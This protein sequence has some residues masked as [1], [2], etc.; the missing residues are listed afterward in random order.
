MLASL[1]AHT[2]R[3]VSTADAANEKL[4]ARDLF[5]RVVKEIQITD[6][7]D[8]QRTVRGLGDDVDLWVELARLWEGDSLEKTSRALK[9]ALRISRDKSGEDGEDPRLLNNL[10][11]LRHLEGN[12]EEARILYEGAITNAAKS[13]EELSTTILYNLARCYE[14]LREVTLAQEAYDKLLAR[15]PEY[16]DGNTI[17]ILYSLTLTLP[18]S[19]NSA[20]AN[21]ARPQP[22]QRCS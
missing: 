8:K 10:A 17:L 3:G 14:D 11:A 19:Q 6:T 12:P 9:E 5:E 18:F 21:V 7:D 22:S 1:R 13:G 4:R 2:R 15:H 20:S 16:I